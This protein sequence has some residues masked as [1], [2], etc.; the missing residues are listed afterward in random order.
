M[1]ALT[2]NIYQNKKTGEYLGR[3]K[4]GGLIIEE[5]KYEDFA[6]ARRA[7]IAWSLPSEE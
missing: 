7:Y 1:E 6:E 2:F 5:T 3:L 4:R